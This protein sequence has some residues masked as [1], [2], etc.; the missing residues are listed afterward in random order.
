MLNNSASPVI[1]LIPVATTYIGYIIGVLNK[2][3]GAAGIDGSAMQLFLSSLPFQ[4]FSFTSITIALL[5]VIIGW[6]FGSMRKLIKS[7]HGSKKKTSFSR[8]AHTMEMSKEI[9]QTRRM[10]RKIKWESLQK[11]R[12][13][14]WIWTWA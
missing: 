1:V 4:F 10:Q 11:E 6:N 12:W 8:P 2:G 5:S 7:A 3:M 14:K 13:K 9:T